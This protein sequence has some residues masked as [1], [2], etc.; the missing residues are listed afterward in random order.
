MNM[1]IG[2]RS[3][4]VRPFEHVKNICSSNGAFWFHFNVNLAALSSYI[5]KFTIIFF[6]KTLLQTSQ[7]PVAMF[8]EGPQPY[9]EVVKP[10]TAEFCSSITRK[11]LNYELS[12]FLS[13]YFLLPL[14]YKLKN[15]IFFCEPQNRYDLQ[16]SCPR[17]CLSRFCLHGGC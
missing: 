10:G 8:A 9:L 3:C 17:S 2:Q 4:T 11:L 6:C 7:T 12:Q 1:R 14:R 15:A 5:L 13:R 16:Q